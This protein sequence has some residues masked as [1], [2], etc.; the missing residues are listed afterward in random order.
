[1]ERGGEGAAGARA[2]GCK[3][4]AVSHG[5]HSPQMEEMQEG[6][7]KCAAGQHVRSPPQ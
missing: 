3:R 1:M 6:F 7:G 5:F 4:L 2:V